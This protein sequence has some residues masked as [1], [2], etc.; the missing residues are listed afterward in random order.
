MPWTTKTIARVKKTTTALSNHFLRAPLPI[1]KNNP[2]KKKPDAGEDPID[3][4]PGI[5][6]KRALQARDGVRT[7]EEYEDK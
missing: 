1:P 2:P 7:G 6:A 4:D 5:D 3:F